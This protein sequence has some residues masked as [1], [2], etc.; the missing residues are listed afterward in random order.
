MKVT[1]EIM[2]YEIDGDDKIELG[3]TIEIKSHW[4][5]DEFICINVFGKEITVASG[6]LR[7]AIEN[8]T[9]WR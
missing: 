6:D 4:N 5:R 1:N 3:T 7:R 9:N 2:V 8:A